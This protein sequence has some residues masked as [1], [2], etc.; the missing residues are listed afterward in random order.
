MNGVN[1]LRNAVRESLKN[2]STRL[3]GEAVELSPITRGLSAEFSGQVHALPASDAGLIGLA[4]GM[5]LGGAKPIV[6]LSGPDALWGRPR[7]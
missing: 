2:P 1:A 3:L 5:A 7:L 4:I 6:E